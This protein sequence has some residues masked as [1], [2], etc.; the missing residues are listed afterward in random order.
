MRQNNLVNK[1]LELVKNSVSLASLLLALQSCYSHKTM[2][3]PSSSQED[4]FSSKSS[5]HT[6]GTASDLSSID[7]QIY[8]LKSDSD[9]REDTLLRAIKSGYKDSDRYQMD[10][11]RKSVNKQIKIEE[12]ST[13]NKKR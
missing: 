10:K 2:V 6:R 11:Y 13:K 8:K 5:S 7:R 1:H 4:S 3:N 9:K 12:E